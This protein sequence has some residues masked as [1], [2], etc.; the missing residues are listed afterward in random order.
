MTDELSILR[1]ARQR[2]EKGWT[3]G[4]SARNKNDHV[5][6][7]ESRA[8][9]SWC[10]AGS[11]MPGSNTNSEC[12]KRLRRLTRYTILNVWNDAKHRTQ[13]EVLALLDRAIKEIEQE[14]KK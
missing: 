13:S 6:Q 4:A 10:L 12:I 8:A 7:T 11:L 5:C 3:Q 2:I 9:R 14:E 1:R